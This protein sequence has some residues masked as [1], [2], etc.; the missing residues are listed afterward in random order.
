MVLHQ[1]KQ[2]PLDVIAKSP[3][4]AVHLPKAPL[5]EPQG[6]FLRQVF[7]HVRVAHGAEQV[8][9]DGPAIT[10]H[11]RL[12]RFRRFAGF[13]PMGAIEHRPL[14]CDVAEMLFD[15]VLVHGTTS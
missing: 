15:F 13:S 10:G 8:T 4:L 9:V 12:L 5:D 11:Q 6:E 7:G 3:L 2:R 1:A 14:G